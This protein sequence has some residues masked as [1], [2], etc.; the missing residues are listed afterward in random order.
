MKKLL[1]F[2]LN[3]F[4]RSDK[5]KEIRLK[6]IVFINKLKAAVESPYADAVAAAI[7]GRTD[8][9]ILEYI[10]KAI[11]AILKGL[12]LSNNGFN[13]AV[14]VREAVDTLKIIAPED[15]AEVYKKVGGEMYAV[16]TGAPINEAIED[17]QKEYHA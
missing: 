14:A 12:A 1:T 2:I 6:I 8:D 15:R 10:R 16:M 5:N 7:P 13:A 4:R 3:L 17:I 11:P 9:R